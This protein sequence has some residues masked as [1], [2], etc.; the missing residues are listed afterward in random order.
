MRRRD[1]LSRAIDQLFSTEAKK[2]AVVETNVPTSHRT[3]QDE[4]LIPNESKESAVV[5]QGNPV[6]SALNLRGL[7]ATDGGK[8]PHTPTVEDSP[9]PPEAKQ[10]GFNH[11]DKSPFQSDE[12][13]VV[14]GLGDGMYGVPVEK[15]EAII[16]MQPIT[17]VPKTPNFIRG[18]T[19]L[20]GAVLP[21]I[22]LNLRL[23]RAQ[24]PENAATR[25]IVVHSSLGLAGLVVDRVDSV[26]QIP[27][28]LIEPPPPM[29][30]SAHAA[31]FRG[32]ARLENDLVLL[33][34]L[35][36]LL[37]AAGSRGVGKGFYGTRPAQATLSA[38][39][40]TR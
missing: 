37:Q 22:D 24:V 14:F 38:G 17:R 3:D 11:D 32:V 27:A 28:S 33:L 10:H 13:L 16:K 26:R 7:E 31:Y 8:T 20:R 39:N 9:K 15:V 1:K 21:V 35:D 18:V 4:A 2:A 23:G 34:D 29:T 12:Q 19:N 6:P 30:R 40:S 5:Y 25:I 36:S